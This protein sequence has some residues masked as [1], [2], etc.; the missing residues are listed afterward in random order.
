VSRDKSVTRSAQD[1]VFVVSWR[2]KKRRLLGF[3]L[4]AR[5]VS[6][7][8]TKPLPMLSFDGQNKP[9]V[10]HIALVFRRDVGYH[11]PAPSLPIL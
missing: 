4:P 1:D 11:E 8:G 10:G 3:L 9:R 5:Q 6:A 2:C 7:Y